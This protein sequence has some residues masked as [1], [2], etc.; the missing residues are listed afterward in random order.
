MFGSIFYG[1]T[2]FCGIGSIATSP[3][4]PPAPPVPVATS[5]PHG[6]HKGKKWPSIYQQEA[7]R[8]ALIYDLIQEEIDEDDI[9]LTISLWLNIK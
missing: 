9:S 4:I 2:Y 5:A 7:E 8:R 6:G 1:Q 3:P